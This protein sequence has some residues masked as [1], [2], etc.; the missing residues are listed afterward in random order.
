MTGRQLGMLLGGIVAIAALVLLAGLA[1]AGPEGRRAV[2]AGVGLA[3]GWQAIVF[4]VTAVALS[5]NRLAAFGVGMLSRLL[6]VVAAAL[7]AV[8]ALKV[9]PAPMLFSL[10]TVLF[11]TTLIEPVVFAAGPRNDKS[12]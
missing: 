10:V 8:P 11:L 7:V 12:R 6:L 2:F 3:A 5:H 1:L 4:L 9:P